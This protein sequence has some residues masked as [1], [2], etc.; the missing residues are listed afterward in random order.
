MKP[1]LKKDI[2]SFL[3]RFDDFIDSELRSVEI[4]SST[5]IKITLTAQDAARAFDWIAVT[6]EF[7]GISDA[8]L[9]QDSKLLHVDMSNGVSLVCDNKEYGF[10]IGNY[11]MSNITDS[12][13]YIKADNLKYEEGR[14]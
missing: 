7:E 4:V 12:I 1:L 11:N 10:A 14:F 5:A 3:K 13:Y 6:F 2:E 8:R 9:I